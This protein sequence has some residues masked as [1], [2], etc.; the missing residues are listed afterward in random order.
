[1]IQEITLY[2][3]NKAGQLC[4]ALKVLADVGVNIQAFCVEAAE[5]FSTVRLICD[6]V[7]VAE[8]QLEK[9]TYSFSKINVL[10]VELSHSPGELMKIAELLGENGINIE[11]GYLTLVLK[12]KKA[13]VMI[14]IKEEKLEEAKKLL[15]ENGFHEHEKIP[16]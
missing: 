15:Y 8:Q 1:M 14:G 11:Y 13:I 3:P 5:E 4:K 2:V 16:D 9:H 10:G 7:E 6:N 12:L